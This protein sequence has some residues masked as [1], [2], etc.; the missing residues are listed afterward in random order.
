L[1]MISHPD[2]L[3]TFGTYHQ[4]HIFILSQEDQTADNKKSQNLAD[5]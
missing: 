4:A 5:R 3:N 2:H 1:I